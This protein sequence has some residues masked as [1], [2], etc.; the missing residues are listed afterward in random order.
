MGV[1]AKPI[2]FG[3]YFLLEKLNTGGMAEV[4]KAKTFGVEGFERIVAVKKILPS[5]AEDKEFISMFIDEAKIAGQL[6]HAN[7]AQIFDLGNIN[8][9]Y[10]IALEY[11][12]GHDL[13]VIFDR[14]VRTGR[15][16]DIGMVCFV[17]SKICEGLDYAHNKK[18]ANGEPM[19]IIHRDISPQNILLSYDGECKL[20]DFGIA[21]ATNKSSATQVGILKGKFSYMSPEQVSGKTNIDRRSDIFALGIV[22]FELLTLKR[23]FLGQSDF[24]TLEKIRKVEV[25][26]P[27]LYNSDIPE[28]LEDI[29]LKALEKD[30]NQRYQ[31]AGELQE[32]LQRFMFS[33]GIYYS[34][35]DLSEFMHSMFSQEIL[36][37]QKKMEFYKELTRD[38]LVQSRAPSA[39]PED[40][41][42]FYD[43]QNVHKMSGIQYE[44]VQANQNPNKVAPKQAIY[45]ELDDFQPPS[46]DIVFST[47]N[48]NAVKADANINVNDIVS[49]SVKN[50][51]RPAVPRKSM[52]ASPAVSQA[53]ANGGVVVVKGHETIMSAQA[54][55]KKNSNRNVFI[56]IVIV[57]I[58][59]II[60]IIAYAVIG[61]DPRDGVLKFTVYPNDIAFKLQID[62]QPI[63]D[64]NNST[65]DASNLS[66]RNDTHVLIMADGY[67]TYNNSIRAERDGKDV[68]VHLEAVTS[69]MLSIMVD[70]DMAD[71]YLDGVKL[72]GNHKF[73]QRNITPGEHI[74]KVEKEGY[75]PEER[76]VT[77]RGTQESVA[78]KLRAA[79]A[80]LRLRAEP[81]DADYEVVNIRTGESFKGRVGQ[82]GV[83]LEDLPVDSEYNIIIVDG[84]ERTETPWRPRRDLKINEPQLKSFNTHGASAPAV[85]A[86]P[87]PE[88]APAQAAAPAPKPAPAP[89]VA[90]KTEPSQPKAAP[91]PKEPNP[92]PKQEAPKPA[93]SN[94]APGILQIAGKPP[95][96][97]SINGQTYGSTPKKLE[98]PAATYKVICTN[99]AGVHERTVTLSGGEVQKVIFQ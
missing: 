38:V 99:D 61:H 32:A 64:I 57:L 44:A 96:T 73:E 72:E 50:D 40:E 17:V 15:K 46:G 29:V 25:S 92:E 85:A 10:Y 16:L 27:T 68:E 28:A 18:D 20:I 87:V 36:L 74:V 82:A 12:P 70:V 90:K 45:K 69:N 88:P 62:E 67:K 5:I 34:A 59:I 22:L 51:K 47:K 55:R 78:F 23:L 66:V 42:S 2:P 39:T 4:F 71:V 19:N 41:T 13:R 83:L 35:K 77:L 75:F 54:I 56:V 37:E 65:F 9:E 81:F 80:A 76:K 21:K 52:I 31:T 91:K 98:M 24:E 58:G 86:A 94:N 79:K 26:P 48:G 11:V 60:G 33:Q 30:V 93:A 14:C 7:I 95:C 49:S 6:T 43:K 8:D 84:K 1:L 53:A 89:A 3:D 63:R 97:I